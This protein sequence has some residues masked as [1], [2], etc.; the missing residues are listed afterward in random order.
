MCHAPVDL[1]GGK[2]QVGG[3]EGDVLPHGLGEELALGVL[4]HVADVPM[5]ATPVALG[6]GADAAHGDGA[7]VGRLE[8]ADEADEG[9]L[10]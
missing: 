3:A 1:V 7:G 6:R 2:A 10:A 8:G 9:G 5:E 4:H